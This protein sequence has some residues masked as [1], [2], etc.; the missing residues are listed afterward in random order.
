MCQPYSGQNGYPTAMRLW[1]PMTFANL[2]STLVVTW[3]VC[4]WLAL[5]A[6]I[7]VA[8]LSHKCLHWVDGCFCPQGLAWILASLFW[9][10]Q[11]FGAWV[12]VE[13]GCCW[14]VR[15]IVLPCPGKPSPTGTWLWI[16]GIGPWVLSLLQHA[17]PLGGWMFG[18]LITLFWQ[19]SLLVQ[20]FGAVSIVLLWRFL[21][22]MPVLRW[23]WQSTY[24]T[25]QGLLLIDGMTCMLCRCSLG[26]CF[27]LAGSLMSGLR[28]LLFYCPLF[29]HQAS[30]V[31]PHEPVSETFPIKYVV[32]CFGYLRALGYC[33]SPYLPALFFC[34]SFIFGGCSIHGFKFLLLSHG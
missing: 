29:D 12:L 24:H 21:W 20:P 18:G 3:E 32:N 31:L 27:H 10:H 22:P 4:P 1:I 28:C 19:C 14:P 7:V 23:F 30:N 6:T 2:W 5:V 13:V 26:W 34:L 17:E 25:S 9:F 16:L 15:S 8:V 33:A 11:I